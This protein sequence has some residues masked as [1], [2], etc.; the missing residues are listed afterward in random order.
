MR[1][2]GGSVCALCL[3]GDALRR[4]AQEK[5]ATKACTKVMFG[6][7]VEVKAQKARTVVKAFPV[8]AIK[9]AV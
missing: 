2:L 5:P 1:T 4:T 9:S 3:V 7:E 6:R 8:S